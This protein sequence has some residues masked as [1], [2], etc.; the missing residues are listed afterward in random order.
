M[1]QLSFYQAF[2]KR[3]FDLSFSFILLFFFW[4]VIAITW[5]IASIDTSSNGFFLQKRIGRYAK[6]FYVIKIKTMRDTH[7]IKTSVTQSTDKRITPFGKFLRKSKLDELPQLWN[8]LWGDMSFV[9]PRPDVCGFADSLT[10][11]SRAVLS[12]RPGITGPAS[13]KYR[14]EEITFSEQ[15]DPELYNLK[16]IWPDKVRI[17]LEYVCSWSLLGDIKYILR[18]VFVSNAR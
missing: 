6:S 10:G 1:C 5:L 4:W 18:T 9:G 11:E 15:D 3:C 12:V 8:V 13:L 2:T 16:V 7:Y 14:N 17:N